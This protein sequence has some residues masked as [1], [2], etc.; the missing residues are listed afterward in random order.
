MPKGK[1]EK[2]SLLEPAP[3]PQA[4]YA[5]LSRKLPVGIGE[6]VWLRVRSVTERGVHGFVLERLDFD[7]ETTTVVRLDGPNLRDIC[8]GKMMREVELSA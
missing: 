8:L 2:H 5:A 3:V 6:G 4:E 7:G 1:Y